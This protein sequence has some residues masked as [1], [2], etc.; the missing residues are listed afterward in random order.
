MP[1]QHSITGQFIHC[2]HSSTEYLV[3]SLVVNGVILSLILRRHGKEVG[4]YRYLLSCFAINDIVYT[5]LHYVTFPVSEWNGCGKSTKMSRWVWVWIP[6]RVIL[7]LQ[8]AMLSMYPIEVP[9]TFPNIFILRGHGPTFSTFWLSMYMGN[10]ATGFP[11]L[12]SHFLYRAIALK[13]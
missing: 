7:C 10:Y 11:L 6:Y 9:E 5:I 4:T 1:L 3:G 13:W 2:N 12:V 8:I